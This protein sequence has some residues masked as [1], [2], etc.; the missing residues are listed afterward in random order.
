MPSPDG[1]VEDHDVRFLATL[2]GHLAVGL[3]KV[4][5]HAEMRRHRDR[6]EEAVRER[7][8]ELRKAYDDLK[9]VDAMKDRFL[10][11]VSHEMRSPLTA[12]IGAASF[13]RDYDGERAQ[14]GE[15]AATI[16][17]AAET[18]HRSLDGLIRV[19][20]LEGSGEIHAKAAAPAEIVAEA[21]RLA[22][23]EDGVQ[24]VI[25][26]RIDSVPADAA[27]VARAVGNLLDNAFKFG[28]AEGVVEL[29]VAPCMLARQGAAVRG[30]AVA[31]LDRGPGIQEEDVAR[32]FVAFEQGGNPLTAKPGGV[33]LGLYEARAIA[34][35][36]GGTL[37]HLPRPGGGSE[38]RLSLPAAAA[39]PQDA[40]EARHA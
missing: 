38:F 33:G 7:T 14:R 5:T 28:P 27:L 26:P 8:R 10:S 12:I 30:V 2:A 39:A 36:H 35:R 34:R 29:R 16:L 37:I 1:V 13:L 4:R 9:A 19:A 20:S 18:L 32:L 40:R 17:H 11:N 15:M 21:L 3:D 31:V 6:L 24:V 23:R 22:G 25:D